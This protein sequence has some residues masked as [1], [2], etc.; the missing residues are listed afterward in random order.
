M[1]QKTTTLAT[2]DLHDYIHA[3]W[4][5]AISLLWP[6]EDFS[7]DDTAV[8]LSDL[9]SYLRP[10]TWNKPLRTSLSASSSQ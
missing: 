10:Q 7:D 9:Q 2:G 1:N 4:C 6:N 5:L 3:A 8:A